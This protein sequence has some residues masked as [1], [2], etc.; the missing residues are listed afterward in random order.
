M[1]CFF[2]LFRRSTGTPFVLILLRAAIHPPS[3]STRNAPPFLLFRIISSSTHCS[4][5]RAGKKQA[6]S[7]H[8]VGYIIYIL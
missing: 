3:L 5:K 2:L 8:I 6:L 4:F 7:L 1:A